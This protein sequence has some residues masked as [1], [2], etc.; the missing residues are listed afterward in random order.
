MIFTIFAYYKYLMQKT[1]LQPIPKKNIPIQ[2]LSNIPIIKY[3]RMKKSILLTLFITFFFNANAQ[4]P[5]LRNFTITQYNGGTQNWCISQTC[6]GRMLFANNNGVLEYDGD[7]WFSKSIFKNNNVRAVMFDNASN[8]VYAGCTNEFGYYQQNGTA[9]QINYHSI[10]ATLPAKERDFREIWNVFRLSH[11]IIFQAG[12]DIFIYSGYG[13]L[14]DI[15]VKS[16]IT[17]SAPIGGRI[18]AA[19]NEGVYVIN[20]NGAS[21][22][23]GTKPLRGLTIRAV[24]P[25]GKHI[26]FATASDGVFF[27]DGKTTTPYLMDISQQLKDYQIFCAAINNKYIAFGTIRNGLIIKNLKTGL[28]SYANNMTGLQN[29]TVLSMK[30][31]KRNN[32]WLG[33][34]NGISYVLLDMPYRDMTGDKY[35]IGT[36][37]AS[38]RYN[39]R[40]YLGT[41][42]GLF[43]IPS[44]LSY[45]PNPATPALVISGQVWQLQN[46]GG[47]LFCGSDEGAFIVKGNSCHKLQGPDGS[48]NFHP[49][50]RH[51]GYILASDYIGFYIIRKDGDNITFRNRLRGFNETSGSFEEDADG[52]IWIKHWLKGIY[53]II[54]NNDLTAVKS[55]KLFNKTN[56]LGANECNEICKIGGRI[57][58]SSTKGILH[59]NK[60]NGKLERD[61]ILNDIF[62]QPERSLKIYETPKHDLWAM[63]SNYLAIAHRYGNR[64]DVDST[65]YRSFINR[66]QM[67]MG[68]I[69]C[70]DGDHTIFNYDKGFYLVKNNYGSNAT[71]DKLMIR[72]VTSTNDSD[73]IVYSALLPNKQQS[74]KIPHNLNSIRIEFVQPEYLGENAIEYSCYLEGTDKHWGQRQTSTSK[75]YTNLSRGT[76]IFHVRSFDSISGKS[77]ETEMKIT[78]LPAWYETTFMICL[79][80]ILAIIALKYII[81]QLKKRAERGLLALRKEEER[82]AKIQEAKRL[83]EKERNDRELAEMKTA[84]LNMELKHKSSELS[85]STIN[86]IHKNDLLQSLDE[87]M[88][89]LLETLKYKEYESKIAQKIQNIRKVLSKNLNEDDNWDTLER[90][91]NLVYDGFID[92]LIRRF[93]DLNIVDR[94]L[95]AYLRMGLRSKDIA[96]LLNTSTRS[97]ET[98]RYRLRKKL[99]LDAGDNIITF[100][101]SIKKD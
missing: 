5:T 51:P 89:D 21:E 59:Y 52:S 12:N 61:K 49:L 23:P 10:S 15:K 1:I 11:D 67:G 53:H 88:K 3:G 40:L 19:T 6:D 66:L 8:N 82:K 13:S 69:G 72:L 93:P 76:Y 87:E 55:V 92:E 9:K 31:D 32:I 81:L 26:L 91:F 96:S 45:S 7:K 97:I 17:C 43:Y 16:R 14:K 38:I 83:I 77:Q 22:L 84:Q 78:I 44:Q 30:F 86:L 98:A 41:N 46:I 35:S 85:D 99:D 4:Q 2:R 95:C 33:L 71:D 27:Y 57:Y 29:N 39:D 28:T 80:V 24:L 64:Y 42:Q 47:T 37:Y 20:K 94:K 60:K 100:L 18:I 54:L 62:H 79:Y 58:I 63:R 90:N 34:D 48:W 70:I 75:E 25:L 56:G 73:S 65:S 74:I 36:G 101:T 68:D 50:K